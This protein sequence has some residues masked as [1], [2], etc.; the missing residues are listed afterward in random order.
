MQFEDIFLKY[1]CPHPNLKKSKTSAKHLDFSQWRAAYA[2]NLNTKVTEKSDF[3]L[4]F[5]VVDCLAL[6]N[7]KLEIK[8]ALH[9]VCQK[10]FGTRIGTILN[11]LHMLVH[12]LQISSNVS[13][14]G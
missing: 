5:D 1:G 10:L 8:N 9:H 13:I 6:K 11:I 7:A 2:S 4:E 12:C 3:K 14:S